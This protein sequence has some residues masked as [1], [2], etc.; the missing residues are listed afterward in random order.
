MC[1]GDGATHAGDAAGGAIQGPHEGGREEGEGSS[2]QGSM[3]NDNRS[4][5]SH[6]GQGEVERAGR[7][8]EGSCCAGK[9][10]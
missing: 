7:E 10:K 8:G 6:L 3:I 5:E 9:E 1:A 2:P 4:L